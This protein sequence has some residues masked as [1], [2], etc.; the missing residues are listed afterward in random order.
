ML[1]IQRTKCK[2][3]EDEER[4]VHSF[5][6]NNKSTKKNNG[7]QEK[8][9]RGA[10]TSSSG[11]DH[12]WRCRRASSLRLWMSLLLSDVTSVF[13]GYDDPLKYKLSPVTNF[14]SETAAFGEITVGM[15]NEDE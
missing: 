12:S 14:N 8:K 4:R 13:E 2:L 7:A 11:S 1:T 5:A 9:G 3:V 10:R 15:M 6:S